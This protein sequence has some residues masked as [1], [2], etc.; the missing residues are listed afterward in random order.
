MASSALCLPPYAPP[1]RRWRAAGGNGGPGGD[2]NQAAYNSSR[3]SR[4]HQR[5]RVAASARRGLRAR[6]AAYQHHAITAHHSASRRAAHQY[7]YSPTHHHRAQPR[8]HFCCAYA[9]LMI[10]R[11]PRDADVNIS[12][13]ATRDIALFSKAYRRSSWRCRLIVDERGN[14]RRRYH[15]GEQTCAC[16]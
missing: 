3:A 5:S 10:I 8:V 13:A 9:R 14:A 12:R 7:L 1:G 11:R 16:A 4:K 6:A 2:G 15:L